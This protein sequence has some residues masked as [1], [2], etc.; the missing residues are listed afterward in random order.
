MRPEGITRF[1]AFPGPISG[2]RPDRPVRPGERNEDQM[3]ILEIRALPL[4][5]MKV[6]RFARFRDH[7]GYFTEP[8][9]RSDFDRYPE[10][11]TLRG[12][13][14]LQVNES[15]S[16]PGT[17]R[18]LHFQWNPYMGKLVR[19]LHGHMVDLVLDLRKGSG[20]YGKGLLYDMP[21]REDADHS[22]WIWVPPGF[23]HGNFFLTTSR[24]EYFCTGEYSPG[25]E[26]GISPL[27]ADI[28]WSLAEPALLAR[29]RELVASGPV[30]S[31]KDRSGLTVAAWTADACSDVFAIDRLGPR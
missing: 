24:I 15:R 28:D 31:D 22:E 30:I 6:I 17:I 11:E 23:A 13:P 29:F 16:R 9:R 18:G 8:F 14:L 20:T 26:A 25:C 4:P 7:R 21:D 10:M 2:E 19:T 1:Q 27:A 12:L 5:D 3:K